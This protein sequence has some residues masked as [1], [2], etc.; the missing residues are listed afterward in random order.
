MNE[1]ANMHILEIIIIKT[2][3][4]Q[5]PRHGRKLNAHGQM[6]RYKRCGTYTRWNIT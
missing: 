3:V 4:I 5:Q 1:Q 6:N 2:V